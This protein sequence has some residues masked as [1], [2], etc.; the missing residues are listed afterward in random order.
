MLKIE[1]IPVSDFQQNCRILWQDG[2]T[3]ALVIDPG[4]D[5][6]RIEKFLSSRK[7]RC[8]QIW[9][10]H[11]HLDHCG[12]VAYL[13]RNNA[14]ALL[15]GHLIERE[16]RSRVE[17]IKSMYG[18]QGDKMT[19]CP[20][21]TRYLEGGETIDFAGVSFMTLF[22]PG[23]SPGHLCFYAP[24]EGLLLAGDTLFAGSIGRTDLPG[25]HHATLIKSIIEKILTL[26]D[27]TRVL[28]GHGPETRVGT[29]RDNNPFL[30]G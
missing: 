25:G 20:E 6:D 15:F 8:T 7:L 4:A 16:F 27:D 23:H 24:S 13:L 12:G 29:E 10:T 30:Q 2:S 21:P 3:E 19:N 28:S 11:S 22:T 5:G 17:D 1:V 18:I 9:L 14:D 26:P